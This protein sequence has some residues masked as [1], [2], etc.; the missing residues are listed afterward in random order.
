[1]SLTCLQQEFCQISSAETSLPPRLVL[2]MSL[3]WPVT[4]LLGPV[5]PLSLL[6]LERTEHH[7]PEGQRA[8]CLSASMPALAVAFGRCSPGFGLAQH[9][10]VRVGGREGPSA[11]GTTLINYQRLWQESSCCGSA[12]KSL[13]SI[14]EDAGSILGL[15]QW[16]KDPVLL[17]A[18][19]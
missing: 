14:Y 18:V 8:F 17:R 6:R 15:A 1:M 3:L 12:E 11:Q 19:V 16:F 13:T 7:S 9:I 4:W 2:V 5:S 10:L